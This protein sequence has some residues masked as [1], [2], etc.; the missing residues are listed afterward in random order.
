[1]QSNVTTRIQQLEESLGAK[2]FVREKRRLFLSPAGELF[3]GYAERMLS[4]SEQARD[5]LLGDTP[6]GVLR[7]GAL[8][9]TAAGRL[10]PLLS[11]YHQ[12]YPAVRI[13]LTTGTTDALVE[14]VTGRRIEAAF[15]AEFGAGS[16][17][18]T[19]PVFSEELVLVAPRRHPGIRRARD[20]R[21]DTVIAFPA[22]CAYRRRLQS[23]LA[24]GGV[25]PGRVLELSSYHA[26]LACVA[27]GTGIAIVPK[28]VLKTVQPSGIATYPLVGNAGRATISLVWRRGECS[29]ALRALQAAL[30]G[31]RR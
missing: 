16:P 2:L 14:A 25:A 12:R 19:L 21:A 30:P 15:V 5:A 13:E 6:R 8:E 23:W 28:S 17:L 31:K 24:A 7:I 4:M 3:L 10:P 1:V 20:V 9:S 22:G 27:A 11:G 26:I 18:E 29:Q